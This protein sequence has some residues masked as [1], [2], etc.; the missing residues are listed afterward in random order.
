MAKQA[1]SAPLYMQ[2]KENIQHKIE[3]GVYADGDKLPSE[4]ELCEI[5]S[6]SRIPVRKALEL[7][8]SEGLIHSFQGKG[9]FVKAPRLRSNLVHI[10]TFAETLAQQGYNGHTEIAGFEEGTTDARLMLLGFAEQEPVVFYDCTVKK[11]L[12][13]R[14]YSAAREAQAEGKAFST[15][16]LY[17]VAMTAI[18][19]M[20][21]KIIAL[22]ADETVSNMLRIP[23]GTAVLVLETVIYNSRL[24]AVEYKRGY[25]RTDKYSFKLHRSL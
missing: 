10:Q 15:L 23:V 3:Q 7:L 17:P 8:E 12:A 1:A 13:E 18:G 4:R 20:D 22:S 2:I 19:K 9:S 25:Y 14:F 24:E 16:D 11:P 21:Q 6:V 5:F